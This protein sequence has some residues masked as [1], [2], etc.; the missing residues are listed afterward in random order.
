MNP[1]TAQALYSRKINDCISGH[2][3][4]CIYSSVL[5]SKKT[6]NISTV[7]TTPE[8]KRKLERTVK[9]LGFSTMAHFFTRSMETLLEQIE[10]GHELHWPLR[11]I[12]KK[13]EAA[14]NATSPMKR[15]SKPRRSSESE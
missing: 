2:L 1:T 13:E 4:T 14:L 6:A 15:R 10:A 9:T 3:I 5:H 8:I 7:R 11:F 12:T